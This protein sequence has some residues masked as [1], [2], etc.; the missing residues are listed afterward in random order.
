MNKKALLAIFEPL[1]LI[2]TAIFCGALLYPIFSQIWVKNRYLINWFVFWFIGLTYIRYIVTFKQLLFL[3]PKPVRWLW[4]IFN[5]FIIVFSIS[6]LQ[7]LISIQD[8]FSL[9]VYTDIKHHLSVAAEGELLNYIKWLTLLG[10]VVLFVG[11]IGY[12]FMLLKSFWRRS[13][14]QKETTIDLMN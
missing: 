9:Y 2:V 8:S 1:W 10:S 3:K 11:V 14:V 6:Q 4:F 12:N 7:H 5:I 13:K